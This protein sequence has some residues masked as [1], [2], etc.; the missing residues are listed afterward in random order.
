MT[1]KGQ[2]LMKILDEKDKKILETLQYNSRQK[3]T[4]IAREVGLSIDST[5]KRIKK[6]IENGVIYFRA[7]P[8]P[9]KIGYPLTADVFIKLKDATEEDHKELI[10]YL[11]NH[12]RVTTLL[13]VMGEYDLVCVIMTKDTNELEE[14][15]RKIR[16]K[17][18][19]I[20]ADWKSLFVVKVHK[21]EEYKFV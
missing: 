15:T 7:L 11:R 12:P 21:F 8:V 5:H 19:K 4:T 2:K 9:A 6:L 13:S 1:Q 14:I 17:F 10:N 20:I 16:H 3:L 18:N